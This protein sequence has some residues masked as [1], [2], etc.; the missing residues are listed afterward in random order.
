MNG[1]PPVAAQ[2]VQMLFLHPGESPRKSPP[3]ALPAGEPKRRLSRPAQPPI[4]A[5]GA[6]SEATLGVPVYPNAHYLATYDAHRGQKFY[7][8]GTNAS[9]QDMVTY[10]SSI[11]RTR[12]DR[13]FKEPPVHTFE[14]SRFRRDTMWFPP[15]VTIKNYTWSGALGYANPVPNGQ[16]SHYSTIIQI[17]PTRG[18]R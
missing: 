17:V 12:G 1:L 8:F 14:L 13:V 15:S 3:A 5:Q 6:P 7:L 9:F 10:Y 2:S 16:P 18:P 4:D 11:L